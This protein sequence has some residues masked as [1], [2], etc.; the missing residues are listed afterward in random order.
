MTSATVPLPQGADFERIP[1]FE[2]VE[3][4]AARLKGQAVVTP[5]LEYPELNE[6]LGARLLIKPENLQRSGSFKFRGAYNRVSAIPEDVRARGVIAFSS[7]NHAQGVA[8]AA[9]I[10]GIPATI[11]M[12]SDAPRIKIGNTQAYGAKVVTYDRF[13]ED[14]EAIAAAISAETSAT[15]I[16][17]Y[18]DTLIIAGQGTCGLEIAQQARAAG[19]DLDAVLICCGGGGLSSGSALA[20]KTLSPRTEVYAVEPET[21]DDTRRSLQS[22]TRVGNDPAARSICD[23]LLAMMPGKMTF[24]MNQRLLAGALAVSDEEVL[25]AMAFAFRALKLVV[26]PGGAVCLAAVLSGKIPVAGRSLAIT[27]SGGNV[28]PERVMEALEIG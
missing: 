16:K 10:H 24:E 12:P 7:G 14:R 22:G 6:R 5:L 2:D 13:T 3:V 27:L 11:V 21:F 9:K 26:E 1:D 17:P 15:L 4:A 23:A 18:D 28:D 25:H 8:A 19:A 20:I